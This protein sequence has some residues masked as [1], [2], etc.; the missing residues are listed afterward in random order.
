VTDLLA[1]LKTFAVAAMAGLPAA[2]LIPIGTT[3]SAFITGM[4]VGC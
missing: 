3:A 4:A 1:Q 2:L